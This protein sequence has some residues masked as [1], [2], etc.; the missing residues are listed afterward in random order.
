VALILTDAVLEEVAERFALLGDAT[1][2]RLVRALHD[3]GELSVQELASAVGISAANASQH[4]ARLRVGGILHRR[5]LGK[6]VRYA[7]ADPTIDALC[8]I[9]CGSIRE[10]A[11]RLSA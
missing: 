5:R 10:R 11:Q 7:I 4:L 6:S 2:L 1:R 3:S 8:E 9:V